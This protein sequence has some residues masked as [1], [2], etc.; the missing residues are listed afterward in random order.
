VLFL[1]L[2]ILNPMGQWLGWWMVMTKNENPTTKTQ[3]GVVVER[4]NFGLIFEKNTTQE[5]LVIGKT[6]DEVR[7][8]SESI[9]NT[10]REPLIILNQDLRVVS[11]SQSFY[12]VF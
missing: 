3:P 5:P 8:Y 4:K 2:G 1:V 11:A 9:T 10:V 6:E 12:E 7:Q